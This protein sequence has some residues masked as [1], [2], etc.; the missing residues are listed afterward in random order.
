MPDLLS[1]MATVEIEL[2]EDEVEAIDDIAFRD[3]RDNRGAAARSLL[4]E[5]LQQR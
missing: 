5:W 4:S 1:D 2:D 3:H